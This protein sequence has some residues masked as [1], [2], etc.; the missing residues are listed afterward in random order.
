MVEVR[1]ESYDA[2]AK[3]TRTAS[4]IQPMSVSSLKMCF[5]R[6]RFKQSATG[7]EEDN[8]DLLLG[9]ITISPSGTEITSV[10]IP[11]GTYDRIE[12]DLDDTCPSGKSIQIQNANGFFTT[13]DRTTIRFDGTFTVNEETT[14][15]DLNIQAIITA[16]NSVN[17]NSQVRDRAESASGSF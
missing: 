15:L 12:F 2:A 4:S 3:P 1:I 13:T 8:T 17:A 14:Q 7:L 9:E 16:L 11:N 10:E 6:L 5:K